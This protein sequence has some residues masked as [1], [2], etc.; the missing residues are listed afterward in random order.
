M[1]VSLACLC[2]GWGGLG[3]R[4]ALCGGQTRPSTHTPIPDQTTDTNPPIIPTPP[5]TR[6]P[7]KQ[8]QVQELKGLH[9]L[10]SLLHAHLGGPGEYIMFG[11]E[12]GVV[13]GACALC[14]A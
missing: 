3:R 13:G 6:T 7:T 4:R 5:H 10:R 1:F 14:A 2:I 11:Q 9:K 12:F 8:W